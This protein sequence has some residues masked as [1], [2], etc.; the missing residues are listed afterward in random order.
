MAVTLSAGAV[1]KLFSGEV[2]SEVDM[3][4]V[5]KVVRVKI[6]STGTYALLLSD[7][8]QS[9]HAILTSSTREAINVHNIVR[10]NQFSRVVVQDRCMIFAYRVDVLLGLHKEEDIQLMEVHES[11]NFSKD[12]V[13]ENAYALLDLFKRGTFKKFVK[14]VSHLLTIATVYDHEALTNID[15]VLQKNL[16]ILDALMH[17]GFDCRRKLP[18]ENEEAI[19]D[20]HSM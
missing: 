15:G 20:D 14:G 6:N 9:I 13:R 10:I 8:T 3:I 18:D 12:R 2:M 17:K 19:D 4:P 5:L 1:G 7:G 11:E 16:V